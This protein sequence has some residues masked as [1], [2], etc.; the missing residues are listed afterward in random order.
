MRDSPGGARVPISPRVIN[1]SL[2]NSVA[3]RAMKRG[4]EPLTRG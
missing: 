1:C 3:Q 4:A 2:R